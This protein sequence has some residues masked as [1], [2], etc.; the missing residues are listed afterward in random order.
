MEGVAAWLN[1]YIQDDPHKELSMSSHYL[2][3]SATQHEI[4]A[5]NRIKRLFVGADNVPVRR[6]QVWA[7]FLFPVG[8][9]VQE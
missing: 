4:L 8:F 6:F 2:D 1:P 7:D 5:P 9:D 3:I